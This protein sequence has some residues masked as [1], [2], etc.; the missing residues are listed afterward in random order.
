MC[1]YVFTATIRIRKVPEGGVGFSQS[2]LPL[3]NLV[4]GR[5]KPVQRGLAG[6]P[7]PSFIFIFSGLIGC[8]AVC[9]FVLS[10]LTQTGIGFREFSQGVSNLPD[11]SF[12][13]QTGEKQKAR[14]KES[15]K[16]QNGTDNNSMARRWSPVGDRDLFVA[17]ESGR[18]CRVWGLSAQ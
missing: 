10:L 7:C 18:R 8:V 6:R 14:P 5:R 1:V 4:M 15:T 11:P 12:L 9:C 16:G 13:L 3:P 2:C 17:R